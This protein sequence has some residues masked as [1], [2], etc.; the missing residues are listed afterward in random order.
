ML[1][2]LEVDQVLKAVV[3]STQE[4]LLDFEQL[5]RQTPKA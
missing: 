3:Q 2:F 1:N 5:L 4:R